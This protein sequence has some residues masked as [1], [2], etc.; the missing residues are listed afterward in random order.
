MASLDIRGNY[1]KKIISFE[2]KMT[3]KVQNQ[4]VNF[5]RK[6]FNLY[7]KWWGKKSSF[8]LDSV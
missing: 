2:K 6:E 8:Y 1:P 4:N 3:I 7:H 5:I